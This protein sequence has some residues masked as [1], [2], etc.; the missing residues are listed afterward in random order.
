MIISILILF[1]GT[2]VCLH[3]F[4][5]EYF[6]QSEARAITSHYISDYHGISAI[7]GFLKLHKVIQSV[8]TATVG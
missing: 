8:T 6:Q 3:S 2:T 4:P 1:D 7:K 5:A